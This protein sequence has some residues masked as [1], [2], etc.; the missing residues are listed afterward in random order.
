MFSNWANI[1]SLFLPLK[2]YANRQMNNMKTERSNNTCY[3]HMYFSTNLEYSFFL[4]Y[5]F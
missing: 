3:I 5:A 4:I 1:H 2:D